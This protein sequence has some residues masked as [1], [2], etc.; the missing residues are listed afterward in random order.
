MA[1]AGS[2]LPIDRRSLPRAG[3]SVYLPANE[4]AFEIK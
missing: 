3:K 1:E 4:I 2:R